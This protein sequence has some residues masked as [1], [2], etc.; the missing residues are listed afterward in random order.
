M[1]HI[2]RWTNLSETT[3]VLSPTAPEAT[4][5]LRI[6]TPSSELPFA[7]HPTLGSAFALLEAQQVTPRKGQLIQECAAGLIPIAIHET[8]SGL[9][10]TLTMPEATLKPLSS[11][12]VDELESVLGNPVLRDPAPAIVD[13]GAVWLVAQLLDVQTLISLQP[14]FARSAVFER[15]L[16]ITGLSLFGMQ[17]G[18]HDI[19]VRSFAPSC[20]VNEDPVCGSGNGAIAFYRHVSKALGQGDTAYVS[21]QGRCVGRDGHITVTVS[22]A[23]KVTVGGACVTCVNGWIAA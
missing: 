19:E 5:R 20:G 23:G 13:V 4:Y 1:Q 9:H 15:H 16:G 17:E 8:T 3:F 12:E 22:E 7:G 18:G 14:D 10:L 2:A 21:R 11:I 6:F